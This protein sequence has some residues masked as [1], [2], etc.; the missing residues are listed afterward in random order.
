VSIRCSVN[1]TQPPDI[2]YQARVRQERGQSL[3]A[4][5][6]FGL[7]RPDPLPSLP[8]YLHIVHV[9]ILAYL[10]DRPKHPL[11]RSQIGSPVR[12]SRCRLPMEDQTRN[13]LMISYPS[14]ST[15]N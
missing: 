2:P 8:V 4:A 6:I 10:V 15:W 12:H 3:I 7:L 11:H 9:G 1:R 14:L 5:T 13:T